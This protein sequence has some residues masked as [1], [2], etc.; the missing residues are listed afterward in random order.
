MSLL[1]TGGTA[2]NDRYHHSDLRPL[3]AVSRDQIRD[4]SDFYG[5][6]ALLDAYE[7][8]LLDLAPNFYIYESEIRMMV[9]V[10][11]RGPPCIR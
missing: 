6:L 1:N 5:P 9:P 11:Y 7:Y 2:I 4:Y 3:H 8:L 10:V